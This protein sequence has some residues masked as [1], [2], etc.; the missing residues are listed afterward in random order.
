MQ[1][2]THASRQSPQD[3][4]HSYRQIS[5]VWQRLIGGSLKGF[6][7]ICE[8]ASCMRLNAASLH[9]LSL[10]VAAL[11]PIS[12]DFLLPTAG[13]A[14]RKAFGREARGDRERIL[15]AYVVCVLPDC[16]CGGCRTHWQAFG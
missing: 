11:L 4:T 3:A 12:I 8:S 2:S 15:M 14:Q 13:R 9:I 1:R 10:L 16:R 5:Q 6:L 7:E